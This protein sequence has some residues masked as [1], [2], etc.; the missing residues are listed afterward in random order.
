MLNANQFAEKYLSQDSEEKQNLDNSGNINNSRMKQSKSQPDFQLND[1][2]K[3][4][5]NTNGEI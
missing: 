4:N 1:E 2:P 3:Q 5:L